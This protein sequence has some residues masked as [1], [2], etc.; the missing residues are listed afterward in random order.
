MEEWVGVSYLEHA[1]VILA[2]LQGEG[3]WSAGPGVGHDEAVAVEFRRQAAVVVVG[4]GVAGRHL[5]IAFATNFNAVKTSGIV[6]KFSGRL[7]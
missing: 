1:L 4:H 2:G 5:C 6:L 3:R 7:G